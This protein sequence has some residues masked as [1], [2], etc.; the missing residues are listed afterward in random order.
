MPADLVTTLVF[1]VLMFGV[2]YMLLIRP[3][4]RRRREHRE[5]IQDL[6]RGD[7]VVTIGGICGTIKK[8]DKD[9]IWLE[10]E[11]GMALKIVK[12]SIAEREKPAS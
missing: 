4:R 2:F 3:E 7:K 12:D 10:V 11:D 9:R 5:L 6:K 8:V 1:L